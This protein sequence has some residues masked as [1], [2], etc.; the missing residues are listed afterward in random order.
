MENRCSTAE[1][2]ILRVTVFENYYSQ[3]SNE[4]LLYGNVLN[5]EKFFR[6]N[7]FFNAKNQREFP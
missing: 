4:Y 7:D 2:C 6:R 1:E 3:A 5:R